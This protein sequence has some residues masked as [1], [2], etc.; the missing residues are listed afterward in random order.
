MATTELTTS[1]PGTGKTYGRCAVFLCKEYLPQR[2]GKIWTNFPI[3]VEPMVDYVIARHPDMARSDLFNRIRIIPFDVLTS[4]RMGKSGPWEYFE[5]KDIAGD[6][7]A[8]D[9]IHN[10]CPKE[11]KGELA[12]KWKEWLGEVRHLDVEVEFLSQNDSKIHKL[13]KDEAGLK[14]HM[15][16]AESRR[17]PFF[18]I[19]MS[20]W[21][22]LRAKFLTGHYTA[23]VFE[24]EMIVVH[25]KWRESHQRK[26][27]FEPELFAVYD[28]YSTPIA[29]KTGVKVREPSHPYLLKTKR[30]L[31]GWFLAR[32]W[33]PLFS[34]LILI[35]MFF[36]LCFFGGARVLLNGFMSLQQHIMQA[37]KGFRHVEQTGAGHPASS[38]P[39]G[40]A[41]QS[42]SVV[43]QIAQLQSAL[44]DAQK[45]LADYKAEQ[46]KQYE[47]VLF[48]DKSCV[49]RGGTIL[50]VGQTV[51]GGVNRGKIV[52]VINYARRFVMLSDGTVLYLV[53]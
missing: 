43:E 45:A 51:P 29:S 10:Y 26:W 47:V 46:E 42:A 37:N 7:I 25:G 8:I 21:Y 44:A 28:S 2:R 49:L 24:I 40:P 41:V 31:I 20:D 18:H 1:P 50:T 19:V 32:N 27:S 30:Q 13:I 22:N 3:H 38:A 6:R 23:V 12:I 35:C 36:W 15:F 17:D 14:R 5:D 11:M 16:N 52:R 48:T 9:E 4:W 33:W 34:R 39:G 53:Q